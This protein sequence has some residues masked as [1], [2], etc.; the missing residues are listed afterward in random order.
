V[1]VDVPVWVLVL[2]GLTIVALA[3]ILWSVKR[4]KRPHLQIEPTGIEN[5]IPSIAGI[6]QGTRVHGNKVDLVQNGEFWDWVLRDIGKARE[7]I[8]VETFLA[9]EGEVT[10]RMTDALCEKART[11]VQ[12]RMMLDGSGGKNYGKKDLQRLEDAGALV[13]KYHPFS[14]RNLGLINQRD[15]RKIVVI[16]GRIAYVGGHCFVDSWL[17]NAEDKKHF[18]DISARI[19]GPVVAQIQSAFAENWI[20]ETGE[21]L[22]GTNLF[23]E[24]ERAGEVDSHGVWISPTGSPSGV[25]LLHYLAIR[26][27]NE[28]LTIQNP[29]FLPDPDARNALLDAVKRG[30]DVRV[31]IPATEASDSPA[32]QHASHHHYGTLL[33][34]GVKLYDYNRTLLHQK[35][36]TI[37][38]C[39]AVIGSA[40]FDDRSFEVND[41]ISLVV[42]DEA[43]AE[44][45]EEIFDKDLEHATEV[46]LEPWKKRPALHKLQDFFYFL[47]NEQM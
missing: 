33:K 20:E 43:I 6:T 35:V 9:K 3:L 39:W 7:T 2:G 1:R 10:R 23:P 41:E 15:H 24:V 47:F 36:M 11:K 27:A 17:G 42:Y 19:E 32:V 21:V 22:A 40:N 44:E 5:L 14:L 16:D 18:R 26:A 28:K 37:D 12:V 38:E 4:R 46:K 8:N 30:V 25:K 29:Y 31:M 34:G 13:R 45:L